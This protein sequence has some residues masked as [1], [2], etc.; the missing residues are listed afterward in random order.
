MHCKLMYTQCTHLEFN[1]QCKLMNNSGKTVFSKG[2]E[3]F[4]RLIQLIGMFP[5]IRN[6]PLINLPL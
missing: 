1:I 6:T 5:T 3:W 2:G 4:G